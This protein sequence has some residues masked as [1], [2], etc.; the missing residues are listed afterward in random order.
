MADRL[1]RF[2]QSTEF[3]LS[4]GLSPFFVKGTVWLVAAIGFIGLLVVHFFSPEQPLRML[5]PAGE[6]LV[7]VGSLVLL[8]LGRIRVALTLLV[9]GTWTI[10]TA[11]LIFYGGVR[12]TLVVF[13][14]VIIILCGWLFG[15]R[16][17]VWLA[18]LSVAT[19]MM[20][21]G[22]E[23]AGFLPRT[24]SSPAVIHGIAQIL[25]ILFTAF[26]VFF[27]VRS[28][29]R[30]IREVEI[31]SRHLASS[32]IAAQAIAADLN[33]AQAVAHFGSWVYDFATDKIEMSPETCRICAL[34]QGSSTTL[35][36]YRQRIHA[37]DRAQF[38]RDWE[39]ALK[40]DAVINEHRL[41]R[42]GDLR[43][44]SQR[45]EVKFDAAGSPQRCV[46]TMQDV[47][48]I[49]RAE[50]ELQI[51]ATA[52]EAQEGMLI[53]DARMKILRVNAAFTRIT[54][55]AIGDLAGRSL[56]RLRS[57]RH[58]GAFYALMWKRIAKNGAWQGELWN[59][60]KNG[61]PYPGWVTITAVT[62]AG[63]TATHYVLTLTDITERKA[64]EDEIKH[65]AFFDALTGLPNRRLLLD[66]LHQAM[67]ASARSG[68]QGALLYLD[69]DQF[70]TLNDSLGHDKGDR[71]LQQ[72]AARLS[73]CVREGDTVSRFGGDEFVVMLLNL[74]LLAEESAMQ[75]DAV[76]QK[77]L[78]TLARP[79]DLDGHEN[80]STTSIGVTLFFDQQT[81]PFEL[82]KQA[83]LAM[84]AAKAKGRNTICFYR[85]E[86]STPPPSGS[87]ARDR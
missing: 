56:R 6:F 4:W 73:T 55:Y 66:R 60:R 65:L 27:L 75:A 19:T 37:A 5:G 29:G 18:L 84:Y 34:P 83:D 20:L 26:L 11:I 54:G 52:F 47:T 71:L 85:A 46:G 63:G 7:A 67:A 68:R 3:P 8:A 81:S 35:A 79:Y 72:V 57:R 17:A 30:R 32:T 39:S 77:I 22:A 69:L 87:G 62:S 14:P 13:Y 76:G 58:P 53:A 31:L 64:A 1:P 40:G 2:D 44:I 25:C 36:E 61:E 15:S 12:G 80:V 49:K 70:K 86:M 38:D 16:R 59:C 51:A 9:A 48:R 23:L 28:Y 45:V 21:L 41:V 50:E 43:W 78:A 24:G 33:K 74:S 42:D 10:I 82:L